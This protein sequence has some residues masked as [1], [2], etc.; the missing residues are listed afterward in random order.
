MDCNNE[1]TDKDYTVID[2]EIIIYGNKS[3]IKNI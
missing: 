1:I 3:L 2:Y